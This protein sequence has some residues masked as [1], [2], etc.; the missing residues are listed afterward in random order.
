M[1]NQEGTELG[2]LCRGL[3]GASLGR[4]GCIVQDF[5]PALAQQ[6]QELLSFARARPKLC[7]PSHCLLK[8][9]QANRHRR[10]ITAHL[11]KLRRHP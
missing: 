3:Y 5:W 7:A 9:D 11:P 8:I 1:A 2:V 10:E 6:R 4:R